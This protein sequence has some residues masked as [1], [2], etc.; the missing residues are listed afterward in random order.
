MLATLGAGFLVFSLWVVSSLGPS[1]NGD[2]GGLIEL[3]PVLGF[4]FVVFNLAIA[5]LAPAWVIVVYAVVATAVVNL[6]FLYSMGRHGLPGAL[7][8]SWVL[9]IVGLLGTAFGMRSV[10]PPV[11]EQRKGRPGPPPPANAG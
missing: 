1:A 5:R 2:F 6:P 7:V 4:L 3:I 11:T 9:G 10:R 8:W